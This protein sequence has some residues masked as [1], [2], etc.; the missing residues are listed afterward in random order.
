[1][2]KRLS[3]YQLKL[4]AVAAM[5]IDHLSHI[6]VYL[7]GESF[8]IKLISV[9]ITCIG[10]FT[11]PIMCF[12]IAEGYYHTKNLKKYFLRLFIFGIISQ[13]PYYLFR[14]D[15]LPSGLFPFIKENLLHVNVMATLFLG[16]CALTLAKA[17]KVNI[18]LKVI[19]IFLIA[20]ISQF[21][22]WRYFG[23]IWVLCFGLFRGN[24]FNQAISFFFAA[25][26]RCFM[27]AGNSAVNFAVQLFTLLPLYFIYRYSG[28]EGKKS[29]YLFYILYPLHLLILALIKFLIIM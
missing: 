27:F 26:V 19:G 4:I 14:I 24:F 25:F 18:I 8:F 12:F 6:C 22:D 15:A 29:G 9:L 10:R 23:V 28:E 2:T 3:A 21:S 11:M 1:M 16:L 20:W 7:P 5:L 13:I 17:E